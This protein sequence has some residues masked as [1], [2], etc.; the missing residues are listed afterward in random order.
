MTAISF[1]SSPSLNQ[2]FTYNSVNWYWNGN[3]W[4]ISNNQSFVSIKDYGAKG[5]GVTD[6]TAAIQSAINA[7][8][9]IIFEQGKTY[10]CGALTAKSNLILDLNGSTLK[11][12]IAV[13]PGTST[14]TDSSCWI[15]YITSAIDNLIIRN[16]TINNLHSIDTTVYRGFMLLYGASASLTNSR[17]EK[18]YFS[19]DYC[20]L[21]GDSS[22]PQN[23]MTNVILDSCRLITTRVGN[24]PASTTYSTK[25]IAFA[26]ANFIHAKNCTVTNCYVKYAWTLVIFNTGNYQCIGGKIINNT[27]IESADTSI[28]CY[29][30]NHKI[31]GNYVETPGLDGIKVNTTLSAP[32]LNCVMSGN[33]VKGSA[34]RVKSGG[35]SAIIVF[36]KNHAV[37][38]NDVVAEDNTGFANSGEIIGIYASGKD[39]SITGNNINYG[40]VANASGIFNQYDNSGL[41][42]FNTENT[43]IVGNVIR[44]SHTGINSGDAGVYKYTISDNTITSTGYG[45]TTSIG[46]YLT[47]YG[48]TNNLPTPVFGKVIGNTLISESSTT[49]SVNCYTADRILFSS[50]LIKGIRNRD[51][52]TEGL[53]NNGAIIGK[54]NQTDGLHSLGSPYTI[55]PG[56]VNYFSTPTYGTWYTN[57]VATGNDGTNYIEFICTASGTMG[58]LSGVTGSI[59]SGSSTLTVNNA[60]LGV[61][62]GVYISI[63]GVSG[64]KR[65]IAV[66]GNIITLNSTAGTTVSGA[67]ISYSPATFKNQ[68]TQSGSSSY[69][70]DGGTP[71]STYNLGPVFDCGGVN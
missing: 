28:Y 21:C 69:I 15:F 71:S 41:N 8:N 62:E 68:T 16:G 14:N 54:A 35:S 60:T 36:G 10:L 33:T 65:V 42:G 59:S 58:T 51:I 3:K 25:A 34:G 56:G 12:N 66:N 9:C 44:A 48:G 46:L 18:L 19:D 37:S 40:D 64:V 17:F 27:V 38:G 13:L 24:N 50:N 63:A 29:G 43:T 53:T 39:I 57:E 31:I 70:F 11:R 47:G 67:S 2:V 7:A 45:G 49:I 30:N 6:D 23:A 32:S 61:Y 55:S 20:G 26:L 22:T 4:L 52:A 1:P 5:D